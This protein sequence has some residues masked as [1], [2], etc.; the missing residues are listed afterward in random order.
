VNST[1]VCSRIRKANIHLEVPNAAQKVG[2]VKIP[3]KCNLVL[4]QNWI[5]LGIN[6]GRNKTYTHHC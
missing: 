6:V 4:A 3:K 1:D 2:G 5:V